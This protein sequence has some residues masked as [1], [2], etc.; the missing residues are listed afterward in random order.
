[1]K[2]LAP[3]PS[4]QALLS[5]PPLRASPRPNPAV[6][7]RIKPF[8]PSLWRFR[9]RSAAGA[10]G[11]DDVSVSS[12]SSAPSSSELA[13]LLTFADVQRDAAERGMDLRVRTIGP[14]W[15]VTLRD[16]ATIGDGDSSSSSSS[17]TS[18]ST[19]APLLLAR[20]VGVTALGICHLDSLV[21]N[22][23]RARGTAGL[24][25]RPGLA[26][27]GGLVAQAVFASAF[28]R[29]RAKKV[30]VLA[31]DDGAS[32]EHDRLVRAYRRVAGF[33]V[34]KRV[35]GDKI[36]DVPH[37]LVWGAVGSRMDAAVEAQLRRWGGARA[38]KRSG[39]RNAEG[40][41]Q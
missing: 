2:H 34:V 36:S 41:G 27:T 29:G 13:P 35:E 9:S 26:G 12:S 21:V 5:A 17:S 38:K 20:A 7:P 10:S 30:E 22:T 23:R 24:R 19:S 33:E 18:S 8:P 40:E 32:G 11:D 14:W 3:P 31:V 28:E 25:T 15:E 16:L 1:M 6:P 4:R 37:Q 39:R